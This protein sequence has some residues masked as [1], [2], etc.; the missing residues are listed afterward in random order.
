MDEAFLRAQYEW[1]WEHAQMEAGYLEDDRHADRH[2]VLLEE[3]C[4]SIRF[5]NTVQ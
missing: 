5:S 2:E 1:D 3:L 4:D